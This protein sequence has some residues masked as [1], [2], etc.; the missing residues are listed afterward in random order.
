[1]QGKVSTVATTS[2]HPE[3]VA[4]AKG[5]WV[6]TEGPSITRAGV[7][8]ATR[9]LPFNSH[10]H[11]A[12]KLRPREVKCLAHGHTASDRARRDQVSSF[13]LNHFQLTI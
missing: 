2:P 3:C 12:R 6:E 9:P 4:A 1:M 10:S 7:L 11:P 13:P 5:L 8:S